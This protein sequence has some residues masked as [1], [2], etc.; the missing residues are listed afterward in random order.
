MRAQ[1]SA[2]FRPT[3]GEVPGWTHQVGDWQRAFAP[4]DPVDGQATFFAGTSPYSELY[5][6]VDVRADYELCDD[7]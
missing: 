4:P 6:D 7:R 5:Q 2:E 1:P 3:D